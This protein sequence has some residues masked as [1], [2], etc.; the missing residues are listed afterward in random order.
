VAAKAVETLLAD[1]KAHGA[2][3]HRFPDRAPFQEFNQ[4]VGLAEIQH[5]ERRFAAKPDK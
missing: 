1:I 3:T 5:L 4:M 2:P